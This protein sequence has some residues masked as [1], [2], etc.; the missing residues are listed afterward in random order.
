MARGPSYFQR[1][2]EPLSA[3]PILLGP[4]RRQPVLPGD[5]RPPT[6]AKALSAPVPIVNPDRPAAEADRPAIRIDAEAAISG[7]LAEA[8]AAAPMTAPPPG[9]RGPQ[10]APND[11][12]SAAA[13]RM[14]TPDIVLEVAEPA[15]AAAFSAP[16]SEAAAVSIAEPAVSRTDGVPAITGLTAPVP[17]RRH[18]PPAGT[19]D[20]VAEAQDRAAETPAA[21]DKP[22]SAAPPR[23][24]LET[25]APS[26]RPVRADPPRPGKGPVVRIGTIEVRTASPPTPQPPVAASVPAPARPAPAMPSAGYAWRYGLLQ[27]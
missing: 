17:D 10:A 7:P 21:R 18:D 12:Q 20:R 13:A 6:A 24:Q 25:A 26:R 14:R 16:M 8:A 9:D 3:A 23:L 5:E 1:L 2:A 27:S 15:P 4:S 22:V 11:L 19:L